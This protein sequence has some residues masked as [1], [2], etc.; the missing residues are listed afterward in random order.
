M[1]PIS[2]Q[3]VRHD[4]SKA[5]IA[6]YSGAPNVFSKRPAVLSVTPEGIPILDDIITTFIYMETNRKDNQGTGSA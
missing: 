6:T 4:D 1:C 5:V 2:T 3:L